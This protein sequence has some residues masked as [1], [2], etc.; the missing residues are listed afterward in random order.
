MSRNAKNPEGHALRARDGNIRHV[1]DFFFDDHEWAVRHLVIVTRTW[2]PG[3][4]A[5][6]S[7]ARFVPTTLTTHYHA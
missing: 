4:P 2:W 3:N 1:Q 5:A 7:F 6:Y